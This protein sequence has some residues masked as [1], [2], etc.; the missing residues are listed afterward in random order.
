MAQCPWIIQPAPGLL[1][2]GDRA[3]VLTAVDDNVCWGK[4]NINS[5]FLRT[6]N[7]GNNWTVSTLNVFL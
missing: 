4:N 3:V 2:S 1:N 6:T 5:Q 7:G